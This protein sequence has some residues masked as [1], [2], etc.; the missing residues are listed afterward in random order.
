[1]RRHQPRRALT[2][3]NQSLVAGVVDVM[4]ELVKLTLR[5]RD[6]AHY[7]VVRN[8]ERKGSAEALSRRVNQRGL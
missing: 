5:M 1:V 8:S 2:I 7:L 4:E 6:V 3:P